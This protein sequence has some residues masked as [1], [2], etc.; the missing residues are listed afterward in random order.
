MVMK[1]KHRFMIIA[2]LVLLTTQFVLPVNGQK[3][4]IILDEATA[5]VTDPHLSSDIVISAID[6]EKFLPSIAYNSTHKEYLVVWHTTWGGGSLCC[7]DIRAQRVSAQ[8]QLLGS[9]FLVYE[10]I[11][12]DSF[13]PS[14][15]YDPV[16][17]RYLVT[18]I[19][20]TS[21]NGTNGD[22]YGGFIPWNGLSASLTPFTIINWDTSQWN[23]KVVYA[24]GIQKDFFVVWNNTYSAGT[25]AAYIS[26][27]RI[28]PD[29]TFPSVGADLT[30]SDLAVNY[31]NPDV[32]YNLARNE[33]L[34]VWDKVINVSNHDIWGVRITA[35]NA[36]PLGG[37][38]FVI[39]GW[40]AK[41]EL[42]AVAACNI[43]DQYLVTWQSD[44][45]TG[46]TDYAIYGYFITGA[47]ALDPPPIMIDDT[48]SP[49]IESDVA[50]N[51]TG[52]QYLVVFQQRYTNVKYG[53]TGHLLNS[54]HSMEPP[55]VIVAPFGDVDRT[56]PAVAGGYGNDYL[57]AWEHQRE[58]T[59]YQDI[60]GRIVTPHMLFLPLIRK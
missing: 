52:N 20:D 14:I 55:I 49:E 18:F 33:Y 36:V 43:A 32:S 42:P 3:L 51:R 41:E 34:V 50:C 26:G 35:S 2:A 24:G 8:G 23:P 30:I 4:P 11:T 7:R 31:I 1:K 21:G 56:N 38:P 10:N 25:P 9:E 6:N 16:N 19:F 17:D 15:A 60:H 29:G 58:G 12:K 40:P 37:G 27:K 5:A 44:Q 47:G 22:L 13:Q 57:V 48:T 28:L 54:D 39:A 59:S 46:G 45:D 53:I